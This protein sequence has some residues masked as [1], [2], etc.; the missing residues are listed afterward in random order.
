MT[1][2]RPFDKDRGALAAIPLSGHTEILDT[3]TG[4]GSAALAAAVPYPDR[5]TRIFLK[6]S[7]LKIKMLKVQVAA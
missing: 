7:F 2:S 5:A 1:F 4:T 3:L 6:N